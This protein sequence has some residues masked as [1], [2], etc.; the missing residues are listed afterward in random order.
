MGWR[1]GGYSR[2]VRSGFL[3]V[4]YISRGWLEGG[5]GM[6]SSIVVVIIAGVVVGGSGGSGLYCA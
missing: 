1:R 5:F 6:E 3:G 2:A 4:L